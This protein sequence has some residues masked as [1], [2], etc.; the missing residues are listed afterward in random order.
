M[1]PIFTDWFQREFL[2]IEETE[3]A[4]TYRAP[5][6]ELKEY[7]SR[8]I[9]LELDFRMLLYYSMELEIAVGI[10]KVFC[11]GIIYLVSTVLSEGGIRLG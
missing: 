10:T 3:E 7:F 11:R 4:K 8:N 9:H 1:G 5:Y 6:V 2:K